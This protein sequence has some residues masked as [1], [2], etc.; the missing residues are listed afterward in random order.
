MRIKSKIKIILYKI[1]DILNRILIRKEEKKVLDFYNIPKLT[2]EQKKKVKKYWKKYYKNISEEW[3]R[4]FTY[5]NKKFDVR[6][7]PKDFFYEKIMPSCNDFTLVQ[8]YEDKNYYNKLFPNFTKPETI[9]HNING[10]FYDDNYHY[11]EYNKIIEILTKLDSEYVIKP[12]LNSCGGK[13]VKKIRV[14]FGK[15]YEKNREIKFDK[16]IDLYKKN[17][18]LQ[19]TVKQCEFLNKLYSKSLNTIRIMTYREGKE[20]YILGVS[21][22][23]GKGEAE[24]DNFS[25]GGIAVGVDKLTGAL[26]EYGI[27]NQFKI[28]KF[29]PDTEES[30]KGKIIPNWEKIIKI[31]EKWSEDIPAYFKI[32]AWDIALDINN[33]PVFIEINSK[34]PGIDTIQ[35]VEPL[36]GDKTE[37]LLDKILN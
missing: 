28:I 30:F 14:N 34:Y 12:T 35:L 5:T 21:L 27:D 22:R 29:H 6:Y 10:F 31:V 25:A 8:A 32:N 26:N 16:L 7:I 20:F 37:Y 13:N 3:H 15:I 11:L 33:E 2:N 1:R 18:V 4:R 9:F 17:F 19:K 36:F 24:I 23:L